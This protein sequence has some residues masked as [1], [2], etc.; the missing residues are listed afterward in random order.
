MLRTKY[1]AACL[2]N[3]RRRSVRRVSGC[4]PFSVWET[5]CGIQPGQPHQ[6]YLVPVI[7]SFDAQR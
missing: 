4:P 6:Q 3:R 5:P 1:S 7:A 2:A